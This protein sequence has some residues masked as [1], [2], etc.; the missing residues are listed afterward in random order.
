MV[1]HK[2]FLAISDTRTANKTKSLL[3][4]NEYAISG[5]AKDG[6]GAIR[7]V[8]ALLPDLV[9]LDSEL[10]GLST[11]Q[12]LESLADLDIPIVL[13]VRDWRQDLIQQSRNYNVMAYLARPVEELTLLPAVETALLN[14]QKIKELGQEIKKL[15]QDLQIRKLVEKAKGLLMHKFKL[16]EDEAYVLMRKKAM[17]NSLT[18]RQVAE[19]IIK[20]L[21]VTK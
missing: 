4:K 21:N 6:P 12:T 10:P 11:I 18:L 7:L 17:D 15:K 8:R 14:S 16:T 2:I 3:Q 5:E 20:K 1:L 13:L 9:I 19:A